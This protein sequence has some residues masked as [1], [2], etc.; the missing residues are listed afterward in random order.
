MKL[1]LAVSSNEVESSAPDGAYLEVASEGAVALLKLMQL[2]D[3]FR[4]ALAAEGLASQHFG[5]S[6]GSGDRIPAFRLLDIGEE[7]SGDDVVVLDDEFDAD[8]VDESAERRVEC[9]R[10]EIGDGEV[11]FSALDK[12]GAARYTTAD[13]SKVALDAIAAGGDPGYPRVNVEA[14]AEEGDA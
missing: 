5:I 9:H 6:V 2:V 8:S 13:L 10:V 3:G 1:Y 12:H 14:M 7:V 11:R 4:M